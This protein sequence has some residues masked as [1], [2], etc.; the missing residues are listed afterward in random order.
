M[1]SVLNSAFFNRLERLSLK[2]QPNLRGFFGG[3][4]LVKSYGQ[5]IDFADY[6][7]YV[8]GDDIRKIDWN[9]Y[10]RFKKHYLKLFT[11]ERQM[12]VQI[13]LDCSASMGLDPEKGK[14][15]ILSAAALGYLAVRSMDKLSFYFIKGDRAENPYGKIIGKEAFFQAVSRLEKI[16]FEGEAD[17]VPAI[18]R[19]GTTGTN[20]GLSIII[21]DFMTDSE[22]QKAVKFLCNK[23]RQVLMLQILSPAE[24]SP[25]YM[26]RNH[27]I[28]VE[29]GDILDGRNVKMRITR[30]MLLAYDEVMKEIFD[31]LRSF[32]V[33][34]GVGYVAARTDVPVEKMLFQ[35]LLKAGVIA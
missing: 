15:A 18:T 8:L 14:Y 23:R 28:D 10:S 31:G 33:S 4:H 26:G 19:C 2:M 30:S 17:F 35:N 7:E 12:H 29:S 9:L 32:S 34:Q 21:S 11:D 13:F 27:L 16:K 5:T 6:R 1:D 3:K 25:D 20:D 22:Y 24:I